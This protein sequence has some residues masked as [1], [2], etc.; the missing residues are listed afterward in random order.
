VENVDYDEFF[1]SIDFDN[2][3]RFDPHLL[4]N[5]E[6]VKIRDI[7]QFCNE[8]KW[9]LP[10]FQRYFDWKQKDIR[11]LLESIFR[12]YYVGSFL[13]WDIDNDPPLSINPILG[14]KPSEDTRA[15]SIILDGQQRMTSLYYAI[16]AQSISTRRIR[17]PVYYYIDFNTFFSDTN[18][19]KDY[20]VALVN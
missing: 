9:Q 14:A 2:F 15:L 20:V 17:K 4:R 7:I 11:D 13:M 19:E 5:P 8:G 18:K 6:R 3:N 16:N 10:N 12:D 1:Q